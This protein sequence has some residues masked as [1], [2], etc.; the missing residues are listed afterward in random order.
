[1]SWLAWLL[2]V[3]VALVLLVLVMTV[4]ILAS[5]LRVRGRADQDGLA[6]GGSWFGAGVDVDTRS[7]RVE[8]RVLRWRVLRGRLRSGEAADAEAEPDDDAKEPEEDE[9]KKA[10]RRFTPMA[11][12]RLAGVG[13]REARRTLRLVHLDRLRLRA[14]IGSAELA[15]RLRPIRL[16]GPALRL[17]WA[18]LRER[19][20][21]RRVA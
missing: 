9:K 2:V 7:D 17:G 19:R 12:R 13:L 8:V 4:A 14:V 6:G 15:L 1:M 20:R 10:K 3:P 16:S 21:A 11:W 5:P 18:Y